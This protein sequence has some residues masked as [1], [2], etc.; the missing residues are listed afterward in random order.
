MR[1]LF[2]FLDIALFVLV[3][4][5]LIIVYLVSDNKNTE[6]VMWIFLIFSG[7]MLFLFFLLT[8]RF[9]YLFFSLFFVLD[10]TT[11]LIINSEYVPYT[12]F[13]LWPVMGV[14]FSVSLFFT[15]LYR[16][17][18]VKITYAIPCAMFFV[19]SICLMVFS[20][21]L[22]SFSFKKTIYML[23]PLCVVILFIWY[24]LQ[25]KFDSLGK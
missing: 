25:K 3:V 16:Y 8:K 20:F 6:A 12:F 11:A 19:I 21:S 10:G 9:R 17:R 2:R 5:F 15:C 4:G 23:F 7:T 1:G 22:V 13:Q 24:F 14:L 18:K